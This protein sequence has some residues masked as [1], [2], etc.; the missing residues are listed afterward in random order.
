MT[1][2]GFSCPATTPVCRGK[3]VREAS[4]L[5]LEPLE[6]SVCKST[7]NKPKRKVVAKESE[8]KTSPKLSI[9]DKTGGITSELTEEANKKV[10]S[11]KVMPCK[12]KEGSDNQ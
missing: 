3:R 5:I 6:K 7:I 2:T 4:Q 11:P 10:D 8:I 9:E 1:D 12:E